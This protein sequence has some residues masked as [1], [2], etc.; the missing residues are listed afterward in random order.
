VTIT[1]KKMKQNMQIGSKNLKYLLK[2]QFKQSQIQDGKFE[3]FKSSLEYEV[4]KTFLFVQY[5]LKS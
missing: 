2:K 3:D 1:Y 5:S 4:E